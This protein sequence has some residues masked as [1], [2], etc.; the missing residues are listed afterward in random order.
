MK[1]RDLIA[2]TLLL[3]F[4]APALAATGPRF[5]KGICS[6][7]FP[8]GTPY[9]EC[10][11]QV[12]NA[13][14]D[15]VEVRMEDRGE[16]SPESRASDMAPIADAAA[17]H[18]LSIACLWVLTPAAPSLVSPDARIREIALARIRKGIELAPALR[19]TALLAAPGVLGR[20]ARMETT[21]D[22]AW[23]LAT[24]AYRTILPAARR[25]KVTVAPEN[26]WSKFLVSPRDMRA[27]VDQ[28][29]SPNVKVH[30]DTGN[31]MQYGYPEDWIAT[32]GSRIH[33]VHLKDYKLAA[34]GVQGRF[35]PL[36]EGDVQWQN[37][38]TALKTIDYRGFMSAELG[39]DPKDND[40]LLKV[41]RAVDKI[42]ELA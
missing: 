5:I 4:C 10:F 3:P 34:G 41:S 12:R 33:R 27:F 23:N 28:F 39:P 19:C 16:I 20:G 1:R 37:V 21:H 11:R 25:A 38:I 14:F 17:A 32:L 2:P 35:V 30:L 42:L 15:A 13:G 8:A 6:A 7:V 29:R 36:L 40:L 18:R 22:T 24:Q 31:V 26:V 9:S